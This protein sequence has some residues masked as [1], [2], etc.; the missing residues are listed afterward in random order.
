MK[1]EEG[2]AGQHRKSGH[3]APRHR[4]ARAGIIRALTLT[5][6]FLTATFLTATFLAATW[7]ASSVLLS[8]APA[9]AQ[10]PGGTAQ[11]L[12]TIPPDLLEYEPILSLHF[13]QKT[14]VPGQSVKV[15]MSAT[16]SPR[17]PE[18][19]ITLTMQVGHGMSLTGPRL[20]SCVNQ[21]STTFNVPPGETNDLTLQ[22]HVIDDP[23]ALGRQVLTGTFE[24]DFPNPVGVNFDTSQL[25]QG[26]TSLEDVL[27]V[28]ERPAPTPTTGAS[29]QASL[30]QVHIKSS[31]TVLTK[32]ELAQIAADITNPLFSP[33]EMQGTLLVEIPAGITASSS[34]FTSACSATCTSLFTLL[35]GSARTIIL[36]LSP[37]QAG[38]YQLIVQANWRIPESDIPAASIN[39]TVELHVLPAP[40]D[41]NPEPAP[42]ANGP[43]PPVEGPVNEPT[44][45]RGACNTSARTVELPWALLIAMT[46]PAWAYC[47]KRKTPNLEI[48]KELCR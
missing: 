33:G 7:T 22:A 31:R 41:T 28:R 17:L 43:A 27:R 29:E 10:T 23:E 12:P 13:S 48:P 39:E 46:I 26:R 44:N 6:T 4:K 45:A 24:W 25:P 1:K 47:R 37:Q 16:N 32:G 42:D 9:S 34:D 3:R 35:P 18:M 15:T 20:E 8:P 30:P 19:R 11:P 38:I 36:D 40:P 5:A 2:Q 14:T 21:C